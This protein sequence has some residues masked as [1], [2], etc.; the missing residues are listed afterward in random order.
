VFRI[1]D[2]SR[3]TRVSLKTLRH[4]DRLGLLAPA[5]VDPQTRYRYYSARQVSHLQRILSLRELGF[6]LEH[7][8]QILDE[9]PR[10]KT[11][12]RLLEMR[13]VELTHQLDLDRRRLEQ[14][15]A[16]LQ[17]LD[18]PRTPPLPEAVVH[19]VPSLRVAGRRARVPDLDD[20]AQELFEAVEADAARA[21]VRAP[22]AP[23][24]IYHD[25][26]HRDANAD[27]EAAVPILPDARKAGGATVRTLP[28]IPSA[29]CVTYAGSYTQWTDMMRGL[30]AWLQTRRLAPA[31]PLREVYLQFKG[32]GL[33]A[34][35]L[36]PQYLA[37]RAED[38][39]TEMQI[40]VRRRERGRR[41]R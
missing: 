25:R 35:R 29:A 21:R 39:V 30:L 14:L 18:D 1:S 34:L 11:L 20:G 13:R 22:G 6:S 28:A 7:I 19:E 31:G 38:Q 5:H 37:E 32:A 9:D 3:F 27:I 4:Y 41:Q 16:R 8:G 36:P 40:P 17:E 10:G 23:V 26:D 15:D 12:R 33:E 2:F 24:L